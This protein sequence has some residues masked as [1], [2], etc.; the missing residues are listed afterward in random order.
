VQ[1]GPCCLVLVVA[2]PSS[3]PAK[4]RSELVLMWK[5]SSSFSFLDEKSLVLVRASGARKYS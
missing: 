4:L 1:S 5:G 2:L 3:L